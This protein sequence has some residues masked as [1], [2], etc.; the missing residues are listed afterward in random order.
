MP[1]IMTSMGELQDCWSEIYSSGQFTEGKYTSLLEEEVE[2]FYGMEAVAVSS[3]GAGLFAV[4]RCLDPSKKKWGRTAVSN[5]TFFATGAMAREAGQ[6]L[7]IMDCSKYDFSLKAN[8]IENLPTGIDSV[9]LT[10]VGGSLATEY[11]EIANACYDRNITLIE[12]AAHAFGVGGNGLTAGSL[13]EAAVFSL[14][15]TK[16]IPVG[17]GGII[18][19]TNADLAESLRR[20]RN[21]GK[22][23]KGGQVAYTGEGFNLR[24]DEWSAAIG[25]KQFQKREAILSSRYEAAW[26]LSNV[27]GP[28][29]I[30]PPMARETN[31]Y[32]YPIHVDVAKELGITRFAGKIYAESDQ[33][34]NSLG[35]PLRPEESFPNSKWVSDNHVCVPLDEGLYNNKSKDQILEF[36]RGGTC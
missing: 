23:R 2:K 28:T 30:D 13:S 35:L 10:H 6:S 31:N 17:E 24:M 29:L 26:R 27:V 8:T 5:N 22:Y 34:I 4:M 14:Y 25:Y 11:R 9:I 3:A 7:H 20:F 15:P 33:L 19:T 16:A 18:V 32:K 1:K 36:L 12:D 21:Y